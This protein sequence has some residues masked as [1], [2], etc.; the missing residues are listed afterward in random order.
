MTNWFLCLFDMHAFDSDHDG[1][2]NRVCAV[3]AKTTT[4]WHLLRQLLLRS[5][6]SFVSCVVE[7]KNEFKLRTTH[8]HILNSYATSLCNFIVRLPLSFYSARFVLCFFGSSVCQSATSYPSVCIINLHVSAKRNDLS[9]G[10][11]CVYQL[12]AGPTLSA[13]AS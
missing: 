8:Q 9:F 3:H 7:K 10:L 5:R 4:S 11:L 1:N 12:A 6:Q 2:A 13:Q